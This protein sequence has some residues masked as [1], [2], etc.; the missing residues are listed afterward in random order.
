MLT[1]ILGTDRRENAR[2]LLGG[3]AE[4]VR[5]R[6]A[7]QILIV[8]EQFSHEA[9]RSLCEVCGDT[10]SLYAEVLSFTRLADRAF[11][12]YGG[13]SRETLD[14]GGRFT[15]L[16]LALEQAQPRLKV[17]AAARTKPEL[18][19]QLALQIE[20]FKNYGIG[21]R[22]LQGASGLF[23]GAFA[24]KLQELSLILESYDAVC[25]TGRAD[26]S[27]KLERLR[28]LLWETDFSE[29]KT[30]YLNGFTDFTGLQAELIRTLLRRNRPVTA[31]LVCDDC[32]EGEPVFRAARETAAF[33]LRTAEETGNEVE[34]HTLE[35]GGDS[36]F[37]RKHLFSWDGAQSRETDAVRLCRAGNP[38]AECAEAV[39]EIRRL[40]MAG[41]R[42]R[43]IAVACTDRDRYMPL[44]RPMLA[45]CGL[46]A[47]FSGREDLLRET[48]IRAVLSAL[49]S[50]SGGMEPEDVFAFLKSPLGPLDRDAC[51]RLQ[52][53][54]LIWRISGSRWQKPW[55]MHPDGYGAPVDEAA[56]ARLAELN[57]W[58][59]QAGGPLLRLKEGLGRAAD[60]DGQVRALYAFLREL[61]A[62]ER[63]NA[64]AEGRGPADQ[65]GQEF[66][67][68]YEICL[69][70]ME[71]LSLVLGATVR[72]A[73]DFSAMLRQLLSRCRLGTIPAG[74]DCVTV[75]DLAA[76]RCQ[77]PKA[78]LVLGADDG[79]LPA[80]TPESGILTEQ[81]RTVLERDSDLHLAPDKTG[82][83]DRELAGVYDVLC[84]GADILFLSYAGEA[85]SYL[86]RR[87]AMLYP[88]APVREASPLPLLSCE[89]D[90]GRLLA[91]CAEDSA[92]G[93]L[94]DSI[95]L[96]GARAEAE[97]IRG[98]AGYGLGTL[99]R[100]AVEAV[101]QKTLQLSASRIDL[102]S[103]CRCAY[104]FQY[105]LR[106]RERKE[107]AMDAPIF[108]TFVHAVLE[109]T[110]RQVQEEGGFAAV[111]EA[112]VRAIAEEGIRAF[113]AETVGDLAEKEPRFRYL[114]ERNLLE[115]REVVDG[116]RDELRRSQFQPSAYELDFAPGGTL[117]PIEV[118]GRLGESR[119][120]GFVDRV[121]LLRTTEADYVRVVD[122]KTGKK[123]FSYSDV[124]NGMGMQM[125]IYLFALEK[126]GETLWGRAV[127][128]AGVLYFPAR[129]PVI[130][131]PERPT[132]EEAALHRQ[133]EA[134]RS[135]LLLDDA[136]LLRAMEEYEDQP[137]YLPCT[138][139]KEG[140]LHGDLA[141]GEE[142]RLLRGHVEKT[143]QRI[144]DEILGGSVR[145]NPYFQGN[146][147][148]ACRYCG[149]AAVCHLDSC[150]PE[151]R[152]LAA[153]KAEEF[154]ARLR[155]EERHG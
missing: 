122:Y 96:P 49:D 119:V 2:A 27:A 1:L 92:L 108:G 124:L 35:D 60:T 106:A 48:C 43:D 89:Q 145:P 79:A 137:V 125:L 143:L 75:G 26:P 109:H 93:A 76:L 123:A 11:S 44:L 63:L 10:V 55:T 149:F 61:R 52:N 51:D 64:L 7:G 40:V 129:T 135:G 147:T 56:A 139:D 37:L 67:Q 150:A 98:R 140:N 134:R 73:E 17:Y 146:E 97:I 68:L 14:D 153:K 107:A 71:Q 23:E 112:R 118:Q 142:L 130:T 148:S 113:T 4:A 5:E 41:Y 65:R 29:D 39:R 82:K 114:Y 59:E 152:Y 8:P 31:A 111:P 45:G 104:F 115:V 66:G 91:A 53:Y 144:T 22:E 155:E 80:F 32:R 58:R 136:H 151:M 21:A 16:A 6:K 42:C 121:D 47:Y 90:A 133:K 50:A 116:L 25:Q 33:L 110:A 88:N 62:E 57:R 83:M 69:S 128:P 120:V 46:P 3:I 141:N 38:E 126:S 72:S 81:E 12:V 13:V 77:S 127:R 99:S 132:D 74:L 54:V 101:Y 94:L 18:I 70:A 86:F 36:A 103:A 34:V 131:E 95:A 105:G 117:P 87:L 85:P 19:A 84:G 28:E 24:Q 100:D 154:W 20:E 30:F 15:A 9:E 102:F 138:A 78:L